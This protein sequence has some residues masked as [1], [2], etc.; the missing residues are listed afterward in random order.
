MKKNTPFK[1]GDPILVVGNI[2]NIVTCVGRYGYITKFFPEEQEFCVKLLDH[3]SNEDRDN[4]TWTDSGKAEDF[5][6][7][8]DPK[9]LVRVKQ[10]KEKDAKEMAEAVPDPKFEAFLKL[11]HSTEEVEANKL[12]EQQ[13]EEELKRIGPVFTLPGAI[14]RGDKSKYPAYRDP[15]VEKIS[16]EIRMYAASDKDSTITELARWRQGHAMVEQTS[17]WSP[18]QEVRDVVKELDLD[19][20]IEEFN[21]ALWH[22]SKKTYVETG[23]LRNAAIRIWNKG[24]TILY[25]QDMADKDT[26]WGPYTY[27]KTEPAGYL[28]THASRRK[29]PVINEIEPKKS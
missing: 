16:S 12:R 14:K 27:N 18:R 5:I 2:S 11:M 21:D 28:I 9:A 4:H 24:D 20:M 17:F 7:L 26:C 13:I 23:K 8:T 19:P 3:N 29:L 10:L 6:H 1:V 15:Q 22:K 25:I